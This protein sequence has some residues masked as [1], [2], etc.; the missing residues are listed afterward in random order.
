MMMV[1]MMMMMMMMML[2]LLL[3]MMMMMWLLGRIGWSSSD[4]Q[5]GSFGYP[6]PRLPFPA[7]HANAIDAGPP[8]GVSSEQGTAV[9]HGGSF[10]I[11][12][13]ASI[14]EL[15]RQYP[16]TAGMAAHPRNI[17]QRMAAEQALRGLL[18]RPAQTSAAREANA[19]NL[20][21]WD[22]LEYARGNEV[23]TVLPPEL[24][25]RNEDTWGPFVHPQ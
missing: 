1:M 2:L 18:L 5:L 24:T 15:L 21:A 13:P 20:A 3:M 4:P 16:Q 17:V 23:V 14:G 8:A 10:N 25:E 19:A 11:H 7:F 9:L 6:E 12:R 22:R